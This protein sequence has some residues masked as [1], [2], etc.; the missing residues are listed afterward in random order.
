[1]PNLKPSPKRI[2]QSLHLEP[3]R[4]HRL[5]QVIGRFRPAI[6]NDDPLSEA[7][8]LA[9][10]WLRQ[11]KNWILGDEQINSDRPVHV[12][13]EASTRALSIESSPGLWAVRLDDP[14]AQVPGRQWRVELVLV[15]MPGED[16]PAFGCTLSVLV[17]IGN[18]EAVSRPGVPALVG[19]MARTL[20]L[21]EAGQPL[22]GSVWEV[23]RP[24]E[25][26]QLIQL[27][28][29]PT[30]PM[31][32]VVVSLPRQGIPFYDPQKLSLALA[33]LC[34]VATVTP[35]A[36]QDLTS[37]YG[38]D[39]GVFGDA[40]RVFRIGFDAD[41]DDKFRHPLFLSQAWKSRSLVALGVIKS[42]AMSDTVAARDDKRDIPSFGLIRGIA[43]DKRIKAALLHSAGTLNAAD[44]AQDISA[45]REQAESWE[46]YA[47]AEDQRAQKAEEAQR[48]TLSRLYTYTHQIRKLENE[49]DALRSTPKINFDVT[50]N[51]ISEWASEHFTG[52]LIITNRA[53][54][55]AASSN[56]SDPNLIAKCIGLLALEYW[57]MKV[58]GGIERQSSCKA[59]ESEL[60]VRI[61]PSGDAVEMRQYEA[62]YRVRWEG[63]EYKLD[64][65]LAGSPSRVKERGLRIYFAWDD[66]QEL[67]IVGHLPTH[68]T[69]THT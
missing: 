19:I 56:H 21:K 32:V 61:S 24:H 13:D 20:A 34:V 28:E 44:V 55:A 68:L 17:P 69:N 18:T 40:V 2:S 3:G 45:L 22:D 58:H 67:V 33:G 4:Y 60:G 15:E 47:I 43:A 5:M 54:R 49:L 42:I 57:N 51:D 36:A 27:I 63:R 31:S 11:K 23:D 7:R 53:A 59:R 12:E 25:V 1:M 29:R 10:N 46:K 26:D 62:E 37:R 14:C 35:E 8:A 50:L 16:A 48:Q 64:L 38:R 30:R 9:V 6:D 65:H 52:R 66:E 39:L 41:V